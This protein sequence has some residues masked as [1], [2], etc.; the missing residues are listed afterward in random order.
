MILTSDH[1][2]IIL[3]V[4][5]AL[6]VGMCASIIV[7]CWGKIQERR[8]R[9][10]EYKLRRSHETS[11]EQ[12]L[13][14][15]MTVTSLDKGLGSFPSDPMY[16]SSH[17]SSRNAKAAMAGDNIG[18]LRDSL[19]EECYVPDGMDMMDEGKVGFEDEEDESYSP[20]SPGDQPPPPPQV[21]SINCPLYHQHQQQQQALQQQQQQHHHHSHHK[22][23][24]HDSIR[25]GSESPIPPPPPPPTLSHLRG[26]VQVI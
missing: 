10:L 17:I 18:I 9:E 21:I 20:G 15:T 12:G 25:S 23:Q 2:V 11:V 4:F 13:D 1:M 16:G 19:Q 26:R 7:S 6:V 3:I 24:R 5:F 8:Q 22:L 14:R